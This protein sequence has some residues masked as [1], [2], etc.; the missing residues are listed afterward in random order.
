[1]VSPRRKG[2]AKAKAAPRDDDGGPSEKKDAKPKKPPP[3]SKALGVVAL[4]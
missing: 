4:D 2:K 1:M 3:V